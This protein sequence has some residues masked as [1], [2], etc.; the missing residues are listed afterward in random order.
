[1]Q[2]LARSPLDG[3]CDGAAAAM[4]PTAVKALPSIAKAYKLCRLFAL[5]SQ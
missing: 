1:M 3:T 5:L 2:I 4:Q